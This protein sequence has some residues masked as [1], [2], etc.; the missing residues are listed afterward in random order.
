MRRFP[1]HNLMGD[2]VWG[3]GVTGLGPSWL[4]PRASVEHGLGEMWV[5]QG[6]GMLQGDANKEDKGNIL[7]GCNVNRAGAEPLFME[8]LSCQGICQG[9][10]LRSYLD[11][12]AGGGEQSWRQSHRTPGAAARWALIRR[13]LRGQGQN[14]NPRPRNGDGCRAWWLL[15]GL[16]CWGSQRPGITSLPTCSTGPLTITWP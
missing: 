2:T 14:L 7:R 16:G 12:G 15:M 10:D 3:C 6:A 4:H 1:G 8:S 5:Q 11:K 9:P 13:W